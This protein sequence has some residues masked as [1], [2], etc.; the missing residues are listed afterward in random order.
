M[1]E[2][3]QSMN[4]MNEVPFALFESFAVPYTSQP[5][6]CLRPPT[7]P[8]RVEAPTLKLSTTGVGWGLDLPADDPC[9]WL[10]APGVNATSFLHHYGRSY[11]WRLRDLSIWT[12]EM[13]LDI[14]QQLPAQ[15]YALVE[16]S[17]VLHSIPTPVFV[18]LLTALTRLCRPG[19]VLRWVEGIWLQT[20]EEYCVQAMTRVRHLASERGCG[21]PDVDP[22]SMGNASV[23]PILMQQWLTRMST[24]SVQRLDASLRITHPQQ[25]AERQ[26]LARML[27]FWLHNMTE[28]PASTEPLTRAQQIDE[29]K[30]LMDEIVHPLFTATCTL[31]VAWTQFPEEV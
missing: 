19:G 30:H 2:A 6:L 24:H 7:T 17:H 12:T 15:S 23:L 27:P 4:S 22:A 16:L 20:Q 10:T 5:L 9:R 1:I 26:A 14:L 11:Q 29:Q 31:H 28:T 13:V 8:G 25:A 18:R 3:T 21:S